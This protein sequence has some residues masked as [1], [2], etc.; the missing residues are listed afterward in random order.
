MI[1]GTCPLRRLYNLSERGIFGGLEEEHHQRNLKDLYL[2]YL[3]EKLR[4]LK[5]N[6][7]LFMYGFLFSA[8]KF[9]YSY[10]NFILLGI[11]PFSL[12]GYFPLFPALI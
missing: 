10:I 11:F 1:P 4:K 6:F 12:A 2:K 3:V 8:Y 5:I 7:L 9:C